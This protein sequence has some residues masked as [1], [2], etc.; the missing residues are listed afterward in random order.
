MAVDVVVVIDKNVLS[1]LEPTTNAFGVGG[2]VSEGIAPAG[3]AAGTV[4]ATSR[5]PH[6]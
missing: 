1:A 2:N 4:P 3:A 6:G 5:R